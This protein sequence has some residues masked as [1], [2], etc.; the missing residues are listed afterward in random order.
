M[1]LSNC[2]WSLS[3][4][5]ILDNRPGLEGPGIDARDGPLVIHDTLFRGNSH[6]AD[7]YPGGALRLAGT[8]HATVRESQFVGHCGQ[9]GGAI[10]GGGTV[11]RSVFRGNTATD[12]YSS[13][14]ALDGGFTIEQCTFVDNVSSAGASAIK[15]VGTLCNSIVRGGSAPLM[16][17]G[18]SATYC[19]IDGGMAGLGNVDRI[20][21]FWPDFALLPESPWSALEYEQRSLVHEWTLSSGRPCTSGCVS[22]QVGGL[23]ETTGEPV[24]NFVC[25]TVLRVLH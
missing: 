6:G 10:S 19:N 24:P 14:G 8:S 1:A 17:A 16:A 7:S 21:S 23:Q 13:G 9:Y 22:L 25:A 20:E 3:G 15:G 4:S 2:T 18:V 11:R 12:T 5:R